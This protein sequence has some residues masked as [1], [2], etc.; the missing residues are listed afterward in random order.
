MQEASEVLTPQQAMKHCGVSYD[1]LTR[2]RR[3]RWIP[4]REVIQEGRYFKYTKEGLDTAI[5]NTGHNRK[6]KNVEVIDG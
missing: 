3:Q 1:T 6:W 4:R 5:R 2:W